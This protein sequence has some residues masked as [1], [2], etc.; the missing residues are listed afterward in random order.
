MKTRLYVVHQKNGPVF[1]IDAASKDAAIRYV[2]HNMF[3]AEVASARLAATLTKQGVEVQTP[4]QP[5]SKPQAAD[6]DVSPK[7]AETEEATA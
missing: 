5:S 4:G 2:S 1:L 7:P 6:A 3:H